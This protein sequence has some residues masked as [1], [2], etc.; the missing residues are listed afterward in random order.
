MRVVLL[1]ATFCAQI[2]ESSCWRNTFNTELSRING[3]LPL[4]SNIDDIS[5]IDTAVLCTV[6]MNTFKIE[7]NITVQP[8]K[9]VFNNTC[10]Y[11]ELCILNSQPNLSSACVYTMQTCLPTDKCQYSPWMYRE[12][13]QTLELVTILCRVQQLSN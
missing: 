3:A 4:R 12:S 10:L 8:H 9:Q 7:L 11:G 1:S 5:L 6:N 13:Y 2:I